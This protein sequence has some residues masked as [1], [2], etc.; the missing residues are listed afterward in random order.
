MDAFY[1][2][3]E[4]LDRPE[5]R[6]KPVIVGGCSRRGVVSAASYEARKFGIHSAMPIMTARNLCPQAHFLPVRMFRYKDISKSIFAIFHRFT[7]L[8]EPISLDEA[9]LDVT[10]SSY[11][12]GTA[13]D[14]AI[15]IKKMVLEETRLT[16]SAGV[17]TSKLIAKIASDF[18]KPDGLTVVPEGH[19]REFLVP[20][21]IECLWGVG[22]STR[23]SL[24]L[25]GV[26]TIGDLGRLPVE[27]LEKKFGRH[28]L[29]M[30]N[31][32]L[33]LDDRDVEPLRKIKS[34]GNEET[35]ETDLIDG[36][37]IRRELLALC[38]KVGR[39]S[40]SHGICGKTL[41]IKIKYND[42]KQITRSTT[43]TEP[44]DDSR[45][46]FQLGCGLLDKTESGR[47][48]VRLVGICLSNLTDRNTPRQGLLFPSERGTKK[49]SHLNEALDR[50]TEK[51]GHASIQPG[52]LIKSETALRG[53]K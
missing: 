20:L 19:E 2:S 36:E 10:A 49:R 7:P 18:V 50:I 39:R 9:F 35:F 23:K 51:F 6:G 13:T 8:V 45:E 5:L 43:L 33:G 11:L 28:G 17:A 29:A 31:A 53:G 27:L 1:A 47:K 38:I 26:R 52:S 32:S 25:L 48:P 21:P 22:K 3:V 15:T 24:H 42:F 34:I 37:S 40:R 4:T 46:I 30:H 44:T 14:I 41:T 12:S 16:V